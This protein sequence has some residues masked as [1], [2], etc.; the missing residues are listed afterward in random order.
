MRPTIK[1]LYTAIKT[2]QRAKILTD[3]NIMELK[4]FVKINYQFKLKGTQQ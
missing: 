1:E 3:E 2:I 4:D